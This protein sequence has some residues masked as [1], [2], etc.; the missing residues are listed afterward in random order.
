MQAAQAPHW[1]SLPSNEIHWLLR[2]QTA[3]TSRHR[4]CRGQRIPKSLTLGV[5]NPGNSVARASLGAP[6]K[7]F[8]PHR[9]KWMVAIVRVS[10]AYRDESRPKR[11]LTAFR[12]EY[13]PASARYAAR[14]L[15]S[16]N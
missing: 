7:T 12:N 6:P 5:P 3:W 11:S 9:E 1:R 13:F 8:H 2:Q 10:V 16:V 14:P 4:R 15:M